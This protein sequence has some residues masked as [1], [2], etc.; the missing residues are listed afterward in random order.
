M[1]SSPLIFIRR[2]V[3]QLG[4]EQDTSVALR[5]LESG[6]FLSIYNIRRK[7]IQCSKNSRYKK[8]SILAHPRSGLHAP[9]P[10]RTHSSSR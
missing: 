5:K 6:L 4:H 10:R 9:P 3:S 7:P 8:D 1:R 2:K